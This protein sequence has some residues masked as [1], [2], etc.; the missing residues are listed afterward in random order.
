VDE[1]YNTRR[2]HSALGR[3]SR[4]LAKAWSH[5]LHGPARQSLNRQLLDVL[6]RT[7]FVMSFG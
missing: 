3:L 1:V 4:R 5:R 7:G 2:L 6:Q